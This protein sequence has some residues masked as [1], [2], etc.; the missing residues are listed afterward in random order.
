MTLSTLPDRRLYLS[1]KSSCPGPTVILSFI[2]TNT[3]DFPP[4][5]SEWTSFFFL[6][7]KW[8]PIKIEIGE[9]FSEEGI[10]GVE[11]GLSMFLVDQE[12]SFM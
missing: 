12:M 1:L 2:P 10:L 3:Q 5:L 6:Y 11:G 7:F 4:S 9:T 8:F